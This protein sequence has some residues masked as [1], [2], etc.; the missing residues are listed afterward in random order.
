MH[1]WTLDWPIKTHKEQVSGNQDDVSSATWKN[2]QQLR[3]HLEFIGYFSLSLP[4]QFFHHS[5]HENAA[6]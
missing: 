1:S 4:G 5:P 2:M 3:L 6:I